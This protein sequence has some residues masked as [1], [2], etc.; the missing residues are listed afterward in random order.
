MY[1]PKFRYSL[2]IICV[3]TLCGVGLVYSRMMQR[4]PRGEW[5]GTHIS[6][7]VGEQS[8][9]IEFDCAHGEISGPLTIDGEGKFEL[10]GTFTR[11]RGGPVRADETGKKEPAIYSG[12]ITGNKMT[13]TMKLSDSN[14]SETFTLEKGK[15]AEL[16]KCK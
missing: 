3:V 14:E 16:F 10:R 9:T 15:E 2:A 11:E 8:A 7:N 4:I 6:M 1:A 13:L 5:G 12:K